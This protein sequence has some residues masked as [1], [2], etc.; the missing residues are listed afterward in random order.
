MGQKELHADHVWFDGTVIKDTTGLFLAYSV[1]SGIY[2]LTG[3]SIVVSNPPISQMTFN[4][5]SEPKL[6]DR[7]ECECGN[8]HNPVGQGHSDWCDRYRK[9][10]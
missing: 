2:T 7:C 8:K 9:E 4:M 1:G 6:K 3:T 5:V 10:F